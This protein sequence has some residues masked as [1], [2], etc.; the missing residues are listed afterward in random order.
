MAAEISLVER[1]PSSSFLLRGWVFVVIVLWVFCFCFFVCLFVC[2][3]LHGTARMKMA[4]ICLSPLRASAFPAQLSVV[5]ES[6]KQEV[7]GAK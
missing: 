5:A 4:G 3:Y 6:I 7:M 1:E 2:F